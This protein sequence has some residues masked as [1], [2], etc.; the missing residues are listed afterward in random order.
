MRLQV[1]FDFLDLTETIRI[2]EEIAELV[3]VIEVGTL[4]LWREGLETIREMKRRFPDVFL[5]VDS[6]IADAGKTEAAF[7][8]DAGA[9]AITVLGSATADTIR[10][11]VDEAHQWERRIVGDTIGWVDPVETA[12]F[13]KSFGVDE[14]CVN[15]SADKT[16]TPESYDGLG[17]VRAAL[18]GTS[19]SV[20]GSITTD[21]IPT[22][23]KHGP[24]TLIVGRAV[25]QSVSPRKAVEELR[26]AIDAAGSE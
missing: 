24:E 14:V 1:A 12:R 9:D 16:P 25:T 4:L 2:A 21:L 10:A 8:V 15:A 7:L 6:K 13:L 26:A 19:V 23:V 18:P 17:A 20:S 11:A 22:I 5:L 3:E